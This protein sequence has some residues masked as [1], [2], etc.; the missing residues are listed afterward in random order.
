MKCTLSSTH[1]SFRDVSFHPISIHYPILS[2]LPVYLWIEI[3]TK[4]INTTTDFDAAMVLRGTVVDFQNV[5]E[6]TNNHWVFLVQE[7]DNNKS[8][9]PTVGLTWTEHRMRR[10]TNINRLDDENRF[11]PCRR[12]LG[13]KRQKNQTKDW[14]RCWFL[15]LLP[16]LNTFIVIL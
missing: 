16:L 7:G 6:G 5:L 9:K 4:T 13:K 12:W 8:N 1:V 10:I 2:E 14:L 15:L 11:P 3:Y